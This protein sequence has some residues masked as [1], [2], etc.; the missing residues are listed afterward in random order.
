[1]ENINI[2]LHK[3]QYAKTTEKSDKYLC[4]FGLIAKLL[5]VILLNVITC[6]GE[7]MKS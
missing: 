1:V 2:V 4:A 6:F 3:V 5:T 7:G